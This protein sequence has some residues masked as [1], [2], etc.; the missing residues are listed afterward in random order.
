MINNKIETTLIQ[1]IPESLIL[2]R[3]YPNKINEQTITI[4]NNCNIPLILSLSS[5][6]SNILILKESSIKIGIKQKK[7]LS[8]IISDKNYIKN[9]KN[10][11]PKKLYI[12]MKNDLLEEKFEIILSYNS[13]DNLS[14]SENKNM[15]TKH[16][17]SFNKHNKKKKLFSNE[18]RELIG[19]SKNIHKM[20]LNNL[21]R[22]ESDDNRPRFIHS[23]N[24]YNDEK[25]NEREY[26]S[27]AVM[28]MRNQ[29]SYLKQMLE[30]SQ[31]KIHQLKLQNKN[32]HFINLIKDKPIS[33]FINRSTN[34][35]M[36]YKKYE[37]IKSRRE[38]YDYKNRILKN[39]NNKLNNMVMFLEQK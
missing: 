27:N 12:F 22:I 34:K 8:F 19:A 35:E 36:R 13:L 37:L 20:E 5:S 17:F 2:K 18:K 7:S 15:K 23:E 11:K 21:M 10:L 6:D 38:L 24:N 28:E 30:H 9:K 14:L 32:F 26:L 3:Y 33:F 16:L 1:I 29:I 4:R 31:R 25:A 39:E